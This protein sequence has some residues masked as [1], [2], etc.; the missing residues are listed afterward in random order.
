VTEEPEQ[1][2]MTACTDM[3]DVLLHRQK[4]FAAWRKISQD[5]WSDAVLDVVDAPAALTWDGLKARADVASVH[6]RGG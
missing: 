2:L 5:D 6:D 3:Q 4:C 1:Q